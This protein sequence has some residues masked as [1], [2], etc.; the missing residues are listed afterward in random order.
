[1]FTNQEYQYSNI[2]EFFFKKMIKRRYK[3]GGLDEERLGRA[4]VRSMMQVNHVTR[5]SNVARFKK[6][7]IGHKMVDLFHL[8]GSAL[9]AGLGHVRTKVA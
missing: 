5:R 4:E 1:M 2:F 6:S 9:Y 8:C 3:A 7:S